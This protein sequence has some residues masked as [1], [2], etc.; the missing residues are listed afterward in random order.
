MSGKL[1]NPQSMVHCFDILCSICTFSMRSFLLIFFFL[2]AFSCQKKA[3]KNTEKATPERDYETIRTSQYELIKTENQKGLLIL[4]PGFGE[5]FANIKNEFKIVEAATKQGVSILFINFNE[6]LYLIESEQND[7]AT[8]LAQIIR[9]NKLIDENTYIGGFSSGGNVSLSLTNYLIKTKHSLVPKGVF[10]V[11]SPVD[12]LELYYATKR[13]LE[14]DFSEA[15]I[16][17]AKWLLDLFDSDFGNP[18]DGIGKYEHYSPYTART[19]NLSNVIFLDS[20]KI[21]FYTEPDTTWW[22]EHRQND[23]KDLNAVYIK[24]LSIE[25]KEKLGNSKID[26]IE[27]ENQGYRANGERHPHSWAIVDE[28]DLLK[29]MLED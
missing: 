28:N 26:F 24:Q 21:R 15:S 6:H 5:N 12:L 23:P 29:W 13:N 1:T 14:R 18:Q 3:I 16:H 19:S 2:C 4:F 9:E 27:T 25:I 22:R 8:L 10:I 20:M 7:L 17:E 11:D